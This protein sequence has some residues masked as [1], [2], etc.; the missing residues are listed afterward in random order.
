MNTDCNARCSECPPQLSHQC[1]D[2]SPAQNTR[3]VNVHGM[4]ERDRLGK[5]RF[6]LDR[7]L[8]ITQ[9]TKPTGV[10]CGEKHGATF[11]TG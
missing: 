8:L 10:L 4:T 5:L 6:N 7:L 9:L 3:S 2:Q 1:L 11:E